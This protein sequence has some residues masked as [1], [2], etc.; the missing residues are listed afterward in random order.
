MSSPLGL[1][2]VPIPLR[3]L[4][5]ARWHV[6][7]NQCR[8]RPN[9]EDIDHTFPVLDSCELVDL[10][11]RV[12]LPNDWF[13][14]FPCR[15][16]HPGGLL[17]LRHHLQVRC[18]PCDLRRHRCQVQECQG[19][20]LVGPVKIC[21]CLACSCFYF[22]SLWRKRPL[23]DLKMQMA[24]CARGLKNRNSYKL[25]NDKSSL[26]QQGTLLGTL[27]LGICDGV[28]H[29]A[30]TALGDDVGDAVAHLDGHNGMGTGEA[31]HWEDVHNWVSQPAHNCPVL[32]TCDQCLHHGV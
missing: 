19:G 24:S 13:R 16:G 9:G 27:G 20:C 6:Q 11:S 2:Y 26:D 23:V 17:R 7:C 4:R 29:K 12:H 25:S 14:R 31:N 10:P 28:D 22:S 32:G 15:C 5:V 18:R 3:R 30:D 8:D 21:H 1:L